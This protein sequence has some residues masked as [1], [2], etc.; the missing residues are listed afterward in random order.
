MMGICLAMALC[1]LAWVAWL[2][3]IIADAKLEL[4]RAR[5]EAERVSPERDW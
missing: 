4:A 5:R 1:W 2:L 3:C